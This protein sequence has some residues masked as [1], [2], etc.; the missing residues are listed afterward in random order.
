M[1]IINFV[2]VG[3]TLVSFLYL[4]YTV[5]YALFAIPELRQTIGMLVV[6]IVVAGLV[7]NGVVQLFTMYVDWY[8]KKNDGK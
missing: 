2:C 5:A 3:F 8:I 4:V 1:K 6:S 7:F